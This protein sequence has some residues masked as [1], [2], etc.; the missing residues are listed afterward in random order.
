MIRAKRKEW[1]NAVKRARRDELA[2]ASDV[3][4]VESDEFS[5]VDTDEPSPPKKKHR[6]RRRRKAVVI[7]SPQI[8]DDMTHV[9]GGAAAA[10]NVDVSSVFSSPE[11]ESPTSSVYCSSASS[12]SPPSS[13][14][15]VSGYKKKRTLRLKVKRGKKSRHRR[16]KHKN[17][18]RSFNKYKKP[19]CV[20]MLGLKIIVILLTT[21]I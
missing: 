3:I 13:R 7:V 11:S 10:V 20:A 4:D 8:R 16:H 19:L 5:D 1:A 12:Y 2:A 21:V 14:E 6:G 15:A 18:G 9:N 17:G